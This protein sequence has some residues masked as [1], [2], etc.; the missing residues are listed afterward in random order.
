MDCGFLGS[1]YHAWFPKYSLALPIEVETIRHPAAAASRLTRPGVSRQ[2][3][4]ACTAASAY[5]PAS[6]L[7]DKGPRKY[8]C[9]R[10]CCTRPPACPSS[11]TGRSRSSPGCRPGSHRRRSYGSC[12]TCNRARCCTC[13]RAPGCTRACPLAVHPRCRPRGR[14]R[15]TGG[16]R[17][18]RIV[19]EL[20]SPMR[21]VRC[22]M[23][24]AL[25]ACDSGSS[26]VIPDA[27]PR[28]RCAPGVATT[29]CTLDG[30]CMSMNCQ[31]FD[32]TG[33][34]SAPRPAVRPCRARCR[35]GRPRACNNRGIAS[36]RRERLPPLSL[37]ERWCPAY[38]RRQEGI[39][40]HIDVFKSWAETIRQD[41]DA[42]KALLESTKAD[43]KARKLAGGA[44]HVPRQQDGFDPRLERGHRRDRRRDGAAR[45]RAAHAGPRARHAADR[46]RGRAS[47]AWR[48]R[49][50]RSASSSAAASTTSSRRTARS[51]ASRRS[52]AARR[53]S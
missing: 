15:T 26:G 17:I 53:R 38:R 3:G 48:T 51:S 34:R 52:A 33:S 35:T 20:R 23:F 42:F 5:T 13:R 30:G 24:V 46:G 10:L 47:S 7:L 29:P 9:P 11:G 50:R 28:C 8:T 18:H 31:L 6:S 44:L 14:T 12:W 45:V 2:L 25:A 32:D 19:H 49:P 39:V 16:D 21:F 1:Q 36:R 41:I 27:D 40:A 43:D 4:N 22:A 37:R